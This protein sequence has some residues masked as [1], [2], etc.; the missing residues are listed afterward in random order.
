MSAVE[1]C[2]W[3]AAF[4]L[5]ALETSCWTLELWWLCNL[6]FPDSIFFRKMLLPYWSV[7]RAIKLATRYHASIYMM[8]QNVCWCHSSAL[9]LGKCEDCSLSCNIW[10]IP[11]DAVKGCKKKC[12]ETVVWKMWNI[13]PC[14][15]Y[16]TSSLKLR[17]IIHFVLYNMSDTWGY[18][19]SQ[20]NDQVRKLGKLFFL[21]REDC[22][23]V[24]VIAVCSIKFSVFQFIYFQFW[25]QFI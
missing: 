13:N 14:S 20:S 19:A 1:I 24:F 18:D 5:E 2:S 12:S 23:I 9:A 21:E 4:F 7:T 16:H 11:T 22:I 3:T 17:H 8:P 15:F 10:D 6:V 25:F